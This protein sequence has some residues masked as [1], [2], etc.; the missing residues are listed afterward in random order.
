MTI[1]IAVALLL[2]VFRPLRQL[3]AG[4]F[5]LGFL[6]YVF[7]GDHK[8]EESPAATTISDQRAYTPPQ[9]E[10]SQIKCT[11]GDKDYEGQIGDRVKV[12]DGQGCVSLDAADHARFL[13]DFATSREGFQQA[14]ASGNP[15]AWFDAQIASLGAFTAANCNKS[16]AGV[17]AERR[18]SREPDCGDQKAEAIKAGK[19]DDWNAGVYG[20][21]CTA[22]GD[23]FRVTL[24]NHAGDVWKSV[25]GDLVF[26]SRS[27]DK[28]QPVCR[29]EC[30]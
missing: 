9:C 8:T 23:F 20:E 14:D 5:V 4:I 13:L 29:K 30:S 22:F 12:V 17:I 28:P 1:I 21:S 11:D 2:C 18:K 19:L 10:Y 27:P 25:G 24:D 7:L 6:G 16:G 3:V 15:Q 26:I